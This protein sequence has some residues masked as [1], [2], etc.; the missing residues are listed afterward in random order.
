VT[1]PVRICRL[2]VERS[3]DGGQIAEH[4]A[5]RLLTPFGSILSETRDR[6]ACLRKYTRAP[7]SVRRVINNSEHA[8][9]DEILRGRKIA[10][11]RRLVVHRYELQLPPVDAPGGILG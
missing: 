11:S 8:L 10:R 4:V 1:H 9:V 7:V 5:I 3:L 2:A 6:Y